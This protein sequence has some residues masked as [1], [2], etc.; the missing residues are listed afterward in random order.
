MLKKRRG[1]SPSF[2]CLLSGGNPTDNQSN[3]SDNQ[4]KYE[5]NRDKSPT[6]PNGSKHPNPRPVDNITQL[7]NDKNDTQ[8]SKETGELNVDAL[9]FHDNVLSGLKEFP[10]SYVLIISDV[11]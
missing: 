2:L 1:Y 8:K 10:F 7:E 11:S 6:N 4:R 9:I 3:Q 5:D